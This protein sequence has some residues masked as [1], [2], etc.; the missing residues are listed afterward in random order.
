MTWQDQARAFLLSVG[1]ESATP[2]L[3][4]DIIARGDRDEFI[5]AIA[6]KLSRI[7]FERLFGGPHFTTID[8]YQALL[9]EGC[10]AFL[11]AYGAGE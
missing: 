4:R 1:T 10:R 2:G 11:A 8:E 3:V 5:G 9:A 7:V 6:G